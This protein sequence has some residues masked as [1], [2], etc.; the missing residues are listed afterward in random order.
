METIATSVVLDVAVSEM[1]VLPVTI[2]SPGL[3]G[4]SVVPLKSMPL[5]QSASSFGA[6]K[7]TSAGA[8]L[9]RWNS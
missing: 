6:V 2:R 9:D 5:L 7:L 3:G 4:L 1:R 8:L